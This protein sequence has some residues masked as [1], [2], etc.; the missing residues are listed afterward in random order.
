MPWP[1]EASGEP[2]IRLYILELYLTVYHLAHRLGHSRCLIFFFKERRNNKVRK[3]FQAQQTQTFRKVHTVM[4]LIPELQKYFWEGLIKKK[5]IE[6][7]ENALFSPHYIAKPY[8]FISSPT[9][10]ITPSHLHSLY[11]WSQD[12]LI[13]YPVTKNIECTTLGILIC[14]L[15][16]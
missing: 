4:F 8:I 3:L 16:F 1:R 6:F 13:A 14:L 15:Y 5:K 2:V 9:S 7:S 11:Q 12:L 10:S